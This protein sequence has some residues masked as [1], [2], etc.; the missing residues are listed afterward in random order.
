MARR[1]KEKERLLSDIIWKPSWGGR[2]TGE[3]EKEQLGNQEHG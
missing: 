2:P 1:G 3:A